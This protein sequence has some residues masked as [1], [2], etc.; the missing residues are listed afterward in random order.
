MTQLVQTIIF[1]LLVGGVYA[2]M[3]SGFTLTFGVMKVLNLAHAATIVLA[4]FITSWIWDHTGIDPL[5]VGVL[6]TPVH[7]RLGWLFYKAVIAR[8]QRIDPELTL[9]ATFGVA[10]AAG[11]V[12]SL[13][14][15]T[16]TRTVTP[17]YFN[18]SLKHRRP[19]HPP[20]PA[21]RMRRS[22]GH[23]GAAACALRLHVP[24]SSDS[25]RAR[26]AGTAHPSSASTSSALWRSMFA[27][28][29]ATTGVRRG[30]AVRA[31]SVRARLAHRLDR[32]GALRRDP[33][34]PRQLRRRRRRR[35]TPRRQRGDDRL[36]PRYR[37][38]P[39]RFPTS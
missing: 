2:L 39:L 12:M 7:V 5:V 30:R 38:G 21:L 10:I 17:S 24:R 11:G 4:A 25:S 35:R 27:I 13:I 34:R 6:L 37:G 33:G 18:T 15:G 20:R 36:V 23:A 28:S 16:E 26:P 32:T 19:R 3:S 29:S 14:W 9:V 22:T 8:V 31:V 1:G